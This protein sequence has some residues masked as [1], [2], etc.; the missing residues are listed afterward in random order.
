MEIKRGRR[1]HAILHLQFSIL[2]VKIRLWTRAVTAGCS[3][4]EATC[5]PACL[6]DLPRQSTTTTG[7]KCRRKPPGEGGSLLRG[8][9]A[10]ALTDE[11][12]EP[13]KTG[14]LKNRPPV[15]LFI[16]LSLAPRRSFHTASRFVRRHIYDGKNSR[17]PPTT[18]MR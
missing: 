17:Q 2:A 1:F 4:R 16:R 12:S 15:T 5:P 14:D 7:I 9:P 13:Q 8:T 10:A 3:P 18:T 11:I 6:A